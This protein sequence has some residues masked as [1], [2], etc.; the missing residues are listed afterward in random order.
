MLYYLLRRAFQYNNRKRN[1]SA[2]YREYYE[3]SDALVLLS[4]RFKKNFI[5]ISK[6][7]DQ[8]K[9]YAISNPNSYSIKATSYTKKGKT[10]LFV[11]RLDFQKRVDRLLKIWNLLYKEFPDWKL[12]I[13]GDGPDKSFY[14]GYM[15]KLK[16]KNVEFV[17]RRNPEEYYKKSSILC[18]TSSHEG[19]GMVLTEALQYKVIP[20]AYKSY[21]SIEDIIINGKNGFTITPFS[22]KEFYNTLRRIMSDSKLRDSFL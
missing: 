13:I 15:N 17:G 16:L 14:E 18:M 10:V 11:G 20:V 5:K 7:K 9:L 8:D 2:K 22:T 3:K 6:I 12:E 19:F 4:E 21:E 1:I